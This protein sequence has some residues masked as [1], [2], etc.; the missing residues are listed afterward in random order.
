MIK[1]I[2]YGYVKLMII[3][4]KTID[5]IND[6]VLVIQAKI[7]TALKREPMKMSNHFKNKSVACLDK[8]L[9]YY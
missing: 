5:K 8:A 2:R 6:K 1:L 3:M 7:S 4:I 9:M